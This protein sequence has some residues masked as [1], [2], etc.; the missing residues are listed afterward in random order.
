[1]EGLEEALLVSLDV[2]EVN[3][4]KELTYVTDAEFETIDGVKVGE[5]DEVPVLLEEAVAQAEAVTEEVKVRT[6]LLIVG[7]IEG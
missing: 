1:M 7:E 3:G 2:S 6:G 4:E 5:R